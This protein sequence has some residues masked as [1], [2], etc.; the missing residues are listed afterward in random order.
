MKRVIANGGTWGLA[1]WIID[2]TCIVNSFYFRQDLKMVL[3]KGTV[4]EVMVF[5]PTLEEF[6]DFPSYIA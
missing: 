4:S 6:Q 2:D 3:L 5:R 1:E